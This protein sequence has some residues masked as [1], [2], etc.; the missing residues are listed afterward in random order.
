MIIEK[1]RANYQKGDVVIWY[2]TPERKLFGLVRRIN[3]KTV[4]VTVFNLP[5]LEG[6]V[7]KLTYKASS[8]RYSPTKI[9]F[10][11]T[12]KFETPFRLPVPTHRKIFKVFY[13]EKNKC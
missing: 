11:T 1:L 10:L 12:E 5:T 6:K 7:A 3:K 9:E 8:E 4:H 2:E 13:K